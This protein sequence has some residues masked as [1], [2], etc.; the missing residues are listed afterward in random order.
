MN[1]LTFENLVTEEK[2]TPEIIPIRANGL[3]PRKLE[4]VIPDSDILRDT[5]IIY[6]DGGYHPFYGVP[7]TFPRYQLPIWPYVKR[8]KYL[9]TWSEGQGRKKGTTNSNTLQINLLVRDG[10]LMISL[11]RSTYR[12][13]Y[14]L[15]LIH[16]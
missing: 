16:I 6:P 15:S 4:D 2:E 7:N 1:Q 8:I 10:Y 14:N 9:H 5:Y 11:Q 3:Q 12:T 13:S